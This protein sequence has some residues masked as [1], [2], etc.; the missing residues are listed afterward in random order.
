MFYNF[1]RQ[2]DTLTINKIEYKL[3]TSVDRLTSFNETVPEHLKIEI[4]GI[5]DRHLLV[6]YCITRKT[7]EIAF[8]R[9]TNLHDA[10]L[11]L[12]VGMR[13]PTIE[14]VDLEASRSRVLGLEY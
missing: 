14:L 6:N 13:S 7:N 1:L 2:Q 8:N 4:K 11:L 10:F 5:N 12:I 3:S 9:L